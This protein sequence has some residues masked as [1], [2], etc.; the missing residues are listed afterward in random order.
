MKLTKFDQALQKSTFFDGGFC[1]FGPKMVRFF[2]VVEKKN[3]G[4]GQN[5]VFFVFSRKKRSKTR[6][7]PWSKERRYKVHLLCPPFGPK[8]RS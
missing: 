4:L 7:Q 3:R 5:T 1:N 2:S 8:S 6:P